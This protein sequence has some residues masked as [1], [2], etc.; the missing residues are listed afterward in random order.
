MEGH[1]QGDSRLRK[2]SSAHRLTLFAAVP[3]N[4]PRAQKPQMDALGDAEPAPDLNR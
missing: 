4:G 1:A 3:P 2:E